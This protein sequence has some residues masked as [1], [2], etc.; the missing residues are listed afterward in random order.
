LT[1]KSDANPS[2]KFYTCF[3]DRGDPDKCKF[4]KWADELPGLPSSSQGGAVPTPS[5]P[6]SP[7]KH[8]REVE[9]TPF[10]PNV[11]PS[12]AAANAAL[13]R[14]SKLNPFVV[15]DD[16]ELEGFL[17]DEEILQG[18]SESDR[19]AKKF[20][21]HKVDAGPNGS[22]TSGRTPSPNSPRGSS[23]GSST[24]SPTKTPNQK[25]NQ[26]KAIQ[27][28]PENPF[29]ARAAAISLARAPAFAVSS[30]AN[31]SITTDSITQA[32]ETFSGVPDTIRKLER[33]L[34]AAE[35]SRDAKANQIV[36]LQKEIQ[37]LK[38][39]NSALEEEVEAL[40]ARR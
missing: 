1:S 39:Q 12:K 23:L 4:F 8:L 20:K 29:H 3:K 35:K 22:E 36:K 40:K 24:H 25:I 9:A 34:T 38:D 18:T 30:P 26:W 28:D 27:D 19:P 14:S 31:A 15:H 7:S 5:T 2:R 6:R 37:S 13:N 10:T 16:E 32:I 17:S 21:F 33:K 11:S